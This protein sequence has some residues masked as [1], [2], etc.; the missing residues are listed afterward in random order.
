MERC[1]VLEYVKS[2]K[3]VEI[4]VRSL[5]VLLKRENTSKI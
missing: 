3:L 5:N 2:E 1:Q 4:T